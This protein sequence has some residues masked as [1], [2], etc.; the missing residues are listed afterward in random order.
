MPTRTYTSIERAYQALT[1]IEIEDDSRDYPVAIIRVPGLHKIKITMVSVYD[2]YYTLAPL[3]NNILN[4]FVNRFSQTEDEVDIKKLTEKIRNVVEEI[5]KV[6]TKKDV[7]DK[8]E[9]MSYL[10]D[11]EAV[12]Y[13]FFQGLKKMGILK[14]WVT[15][16]RYQK[17]VRPIDTLTIY[18]FLWLFNFDGLK[19][20]VKLLMEKIIQDTNY[21]LPTVSTNY[22]NWDTYKE[23]LQKAHER[24]PWKSSA[25]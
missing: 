20:N 14:W 13:E 19:K 12:R 10:F 22:G 11:E 3:Q 17:C 5:S 7:Q 4:Y 1:D 18:C 16:R 21:Q 6:K 23:R 25:N 2:F 24:E 9:S 8:S 15:W